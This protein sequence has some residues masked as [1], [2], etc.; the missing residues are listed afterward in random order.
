[1]VLS[2]VRNFIS[3]ESGSAN[4]LLGAPEV[5]KKVSK[6]ISDVDKA[7]D[8]V[9]DAALQK[10]GL[11]R[12]YPD[13][14]RAD[15]QVAADLREMAAGP[16]YYRAKA[17]RIV[18]KITDGMTREQEK[19]FVLLA[20]KDSREWL[21]ANKLGEY[22]KY[23]TDPRIEKALTDYKPEEEALRAKQKA[24]GGPTIDEDYLRRVYAEHVAG[25]ADDKGEKEPARVNANRVITPQ[26]AN[27][28]GRSASP[29]YYYNNGL[30]EF[31]PSFATR[32]VATNMKLAEHEAAIHFLSKA[33][34]ID[35][36]DGLP[37]NIT[38][39][40]QTYFRPDVARLIKETK[41]ASSESKAIA[42]DLGVDQLPKPKDVRE[43][44]VYDPTPADKSDYQA[45]KLAQKVKEASDNASGTKL[46]PED[47]DELLKQS[48]A[49]NYS[50][51]PL[52]VGPKDIVEAFQSGA[53]H[54]LPDL[55]RAVGDAISPASGFVRRQVIGMGLG[56]PHI[57]NILRRVMQTSPGAQLD[58]RSYVRAAKVLF[59]Q[60]LRKRGVS[61]VDDPAFDTLLRHAGISDRGIEAY[62][63]Y[64]N[65]NLDADRMA[66][67][68]NLI[69]AA[70]QDWKEYEK[71]LLAEIKA[72]HGEGGL[73][74][75]SKAATTA[76]SGAVESTT[77]PLNFVGHRLIFA[78]GGIDQKAR[79]WLYDF[80]KSQ[81]PNITDDQMAQRINDQ[82]GRYNKASW[83]NAQKDAEPFTF[84]PGW[85]Y[86]SVAWVLRHP[87]RTTLPVALL[88]LLANQVLYHAGK[89]K[90]ADS[91][92]L[93]HVHYG[94]YSITDNLFRER[95]ASAQAGT[96]LRFAQSALLHKN[97]EQALRDSLAGV[98][99]D[100]RAFVGMLNPLAATPIEVATGKDLG[101]GR[102]IV[103]Q[104]DKGH[105]GKPEKDWLWYASHKAFPAYTE[106]AAPEKNATPATFALHN[107]GTSVYKGS[108]KR[109]R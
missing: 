35:S 60:E 24:L 90:R 99:S 49:I 23:I 51:H 22:Q 41:A 9:T 10:A 66:R 63:D 33:T 46:R 31:G 82:F 95:L 21:Q 85:D 97:N 32:Y 108:K 4:P 19:G 15:P 44:A 47:M 25:V 13:V 38:Y 42:D 16:Q 40:G 84:F 65:S 11:G 55:V 52:Y 86:S 26:M 57:K 27:K 59:S 17:E 70:G 83:T 79:L 48:A 107:I 62:R 58:P 14:E 91:T 5:V 29:E 88:V 105:V 102:D 74:G 75:I 106:L 34:K 72:A 6:I 45:K 77:R 100:A 64:V 43:Y 101:T 94:N 7:Y 56:I 68:W 98:P 67:A 12:A 89:N 1:M 28:K 87:L 71:N 37:E 104:G 53:K 18:H 92:D 61:G 81:D 2:P 30:H 96:A 73:R 36:K 69:K 93:A 54:V 109:R 39:N 80:I 8:R 78:P 3:S 20:D 76:V 103:P 50:S